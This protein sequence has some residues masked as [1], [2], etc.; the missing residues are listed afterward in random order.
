MRQLVTQTSFAGLRRLGIGGRHIHDSWGQIDAYLRQKLGPEFANIFAEP[1]EGQAGETLWFV[2]EEGAVE[3][4]AVL[5]DGRREEL[6]GK[7][8]SRIEAITAHL[9]T[10]E[11]SKRSDEQVLRETI[12][13]A[14][15]IPETD[16]GRTFLYSVN[17]SPVMVNWGTRRDNSD[18]REEVLRDF[19]VGEQTR[20]YDNRANKDGV[21]GTE[22]QGHDHARIVAGPNTVTR[23]IVFVDRG[24]P[25]TVLLWLLFGMLMAAI[26]YLML[27]SCGVLGGRLGHYCPIASAEV[28]HDNDELHAEQE[29]EDQLLDEINRLE[30]EFAQLPHCENPALVNPGTRTPGSGGQT[31][32]PDPTTVNPNLDEN[33]NELLDDQSTEELEQDFEERIEQEGGTEGELT[34]TLIWE[35][36]ADL[37]LSVVCP[38]G[39]TIDYNG[40]FSPACGGRLDIDTNQRTANISP[41]PIENITWENTPPRGA[42]TIKVNNYAADRSAGRRIEVPFVI[43]IK[44]GDSVEHIRGA[45]S[46]ADGERDVHRLVIQ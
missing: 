1:V 18:P 12:Q 19:L 30:R 6:V 41:D 2:T 22:P 9:G 17:G 25:W 34:I 45:I 39:S 13:R 23:E 42:Y 36:D 20:L 16:D 38:D 29:R 3:S 33:G 44:R 32:I 27:I 37:D 8:K 24:L 28:L 7:L 21:L 5:S 10:L 4:Y 31:P 15:V 43:Q 14:L 11:T 26:M 35:G 46:H 40:P